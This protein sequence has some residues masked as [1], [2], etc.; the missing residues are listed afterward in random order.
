MNDGNFRNVTFRNSSATNEINGVNGYALFMTFTLIAFAILI[1]IGNGLTILAYLK[2]RS[3]RM[4][5]FNVFII[6]LAVADVTVGVITVPVHATIVTLPQVLFYELSTGLQDTLSLF[7]S[8]PVVIS[9]CCILLMTID[10]FRMVK[11]PVKY[12]LTTSN[13][14]NAKLVVFTC[15]TGVVYCF[16]PWLMTYMHLWI[17]NSTSSE[18]FIF[19][20]RLIP[21]INFYLPCAALVTTNVLFIIYLRRQMSKITFGKLARSNKNID[22][23]RHVHS[24][25]LDIPTLVEHGVNDS[26]VTVSMSANRVNDGKIIL[27][28]LRKVS[29]NLFVLVIA[30]LMCWCPV[31]ILVTLV[32]LFSLHLP[33]L[34]IDITV[35]L[36]IFNSVINP[37]IY[38]FINPKFRHAM[39]KVVMTAVA[40]GHSAKRRTLAATQT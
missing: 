6:N 33:K 16:L 4:V 31:H 19:Y 32:G 28:K 22:E 13:K 36:V 29:F 8:T 25:V 10:R 7:G 18:Q 9:V 1:F 11:D 5:P 2:E 39:I 14:G 37:V 21:F 24:E 17:F 27:R 20:Y 35:L 23:Q 30:Y 38:A 40:A 26:D 12:R 15:V 34:V 3:L